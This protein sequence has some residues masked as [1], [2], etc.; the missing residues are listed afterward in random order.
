MDY[1]VCVWTVWSVRCVVWTIRY[2]YGLS[3]QSGVCME[4]Q[5][6]VWTIRYVYGLSD[7]SDVCRDYQVCVW[8]AWCSF[9]QNP[10]TTERLY[11]QIGLVASAMAFSWSK[12]NGEVDSASVVLQGAEAMQ[13]EPLLEVGL[14]L[15]GACIKLC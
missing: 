6:W 2:V 9:P 10:I 13:D 14:L 8:M 1:Q 7:Q 5:V 15:C 12:W 4:Y 11:D 3:D